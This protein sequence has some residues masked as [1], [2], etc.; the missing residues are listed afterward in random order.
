M[1]P[2]ARTVLT[3]T[4]LAVV[5]TL[6]FLHSIAAAQCP[7]PPPKSLL[8]E[9]EV[10]L[11]FDPLGTLTCADLTVGVPTPLYVV[12][13]VPEGGVAEFEVPELLTDQLP[14]ELILIGTGSFP[15]GSSYDQLIVID[16][17]SRGRRP[18][19]NSCPVDPG[20]LLVISVV[21]VM[22]AAPL[23]DTAC[24]QTSCSTIA[25][26]V[27]GAPAYERC[28]NGATGTFAGWD[29]MCVGF[30]VPVPVASSTWGALKA[31]YT[32]E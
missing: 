27:A 25:G 24:F 10:G 2:V 11:F 6:G 26:P 12:V 30:G 4:F 28:D 13:R 7:P 23:R 31:L 1:I 17:C 16:G 9:G 21:Q 15:P 20:D 22:A 3:I 14:A 8:T 19:Q 29:A 5:A 32:A 18:D